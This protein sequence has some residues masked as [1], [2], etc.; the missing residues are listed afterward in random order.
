MKR[1]IVS[2][3]VAA[4]LGGGAMVANASGPG[5]NGHNNYGLCN[6]YQSGSQQGQNQKQAHGQSFL[7]LAQ[8]AGDYNGDG[9][10]DS[11]D[12]IAWCNDNAPKPGNG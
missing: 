3:A 6:A 2:A 5:P 9:K 7:A 10:Q 8:T 11:S 1:I 12:V 4:L